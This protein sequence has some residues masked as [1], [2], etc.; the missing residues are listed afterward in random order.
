MDRK[1]ILKQ[2]NQYSR[3]DN[4]IDYEKLSDE[5]LEKH[6]ELLNKS[7]DKYF[8]KYFDD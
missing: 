7:F 1:D 2:L 5:D 8:D 3:I 6:L 4:Y